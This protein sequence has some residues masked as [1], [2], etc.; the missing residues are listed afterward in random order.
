[1]PRLRLN[2]RELGAWEVV[3]YFDVPV[4]GEPVYALGTKPIGMFVFTPDGHI[5]VSLMTNPRVAE[6]KVTD[7]DPDQEGR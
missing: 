4:G 2:I 7:P 3:Q 5:S 1:M 6:S